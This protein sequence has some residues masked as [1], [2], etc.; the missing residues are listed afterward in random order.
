[1][2]NIGFY[3]L[4]GDQQAALKLVCQLIK[5]AQNKQQQV[6]CLMPDAKSAESLDTMLWDFDPGEFIPHGIG[7]D[8]YPVAIISDPEPMDHHQVLIN[9]Q[10][11]IP[12][13][14]SRFERVLEIIYGQP[15]YEQAKR[16]N[17]RFYK[18]RGYPLSFHDLSKQFSG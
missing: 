1:V 9:L 2:T 10:S 7:A 4:S 13:W 11:E 17:F 18:E 16:N 8:H 5:K 3:K 6:L 15:D 14:F 12:S